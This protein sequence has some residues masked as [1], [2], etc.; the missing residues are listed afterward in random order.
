MTA[1]SQGGMYQYSESALAAFWSIWVTR[2]GQK[3]S[4]LGATT[5]LSPRGNET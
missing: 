4:E 2:K 1:V 3:S 5:T